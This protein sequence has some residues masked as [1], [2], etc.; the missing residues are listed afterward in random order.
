VRSLHRR[1]A[2]ALQRALIRFRVYTVPEAVTML[3][4][5]GFSWGDLGSDDNVINFQRTIL[6]LQ[7]SLEDSFVRAAAATGAPA[8]LLCD[9]GAM[10][11]AAYMPRPLWAEM[12]RRHARD[13][14]AEAFDLDRA[15]IAYCD[16]YDAIFH[17]VTAA[18]GAERFYTL[19]N[20]TAARHETPDL[21]RGQDAKTQTAWSKHPRQIVFDNSAKSL[22]FEGK[23]QR[24]VESAAKIVGLPVLP[25][26]TR[27]FLLEETPVEATFARHS[28]ALTSFTVTKTFLLGAPTAVT[29]RDVS[30]D[31]GGPAAS[32]LPRVA[33]SYVR[34]RTQAGAAS[35]GYAAVLVDPVTGERFER[36][37]R[38]TPREYAAYLANA[39]PQRK[40]IHQQRF[41]F[42]WCNQSFVI[43]KY[44]DRN[45]AILHCQA[46]RQDGSID[47]PPF[48]RVKAEI[49]TDQTLSAHHLSTL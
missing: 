26:G 9:R 36:K 19:E 12:L 27:K 15:E 7:L 18:A 46:A 29:P 40:P 43:H 1:G 31:V 16:R 24:V 47:F 49:T 20:N 6:D 25:K 37:R 39:D 4:T 33:H 38:C 11:G 2:R 45:L 44:L 10:D 8:V 17:M 21:A 30:F 32:D 22:G 48:L 42:L 5:N 35:Y 23:L 41:H 13:L 14:G 3:C 28:V 34:K